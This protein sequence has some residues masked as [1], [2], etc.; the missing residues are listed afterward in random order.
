MGF[1]EMRKYKILGILIPMEHFPKRQVNTNPCTHMG[2]LL[3]NYPTFSLFVQ[4]EQIAAP[5]STSLLLPDNL[6]CWQIT[7]M[8]ALRFLPCCI[9]PPGDLSTHDYNQVPLFVP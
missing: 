4:R 2:F 6:Y 1:A 5:D 8:E 3:E 9:P 7:C